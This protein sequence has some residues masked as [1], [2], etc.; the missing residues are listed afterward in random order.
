MSGMDWRK[1]TFSWA[2]G[3]C[4]EV[5]TMPLVA[6]RDTKDNETGPVLTFTRGQWEKFTRAIQA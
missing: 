1:S 3:N 2:N 5:A 4:V 6:V